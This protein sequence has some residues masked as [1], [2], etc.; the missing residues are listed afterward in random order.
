MN[1]FQNT[2]DARLREWKDLRS[3]VASMSTDDACIAIDHWWQHA[4]LVTHHL[5][6]SD[7]SNWPDPW[8]ML[9]ENTYSTLT[10]AVGICYTLFMCGI[11]DVKLVQAT[12]QQCEDHVLVL[13]GKKPQYILNYW[14]GTVLSNK[15]SDFTVLRELNI[16]HLNDSVR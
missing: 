2:Y 10:R 9:S 7:S 12:D 11:T 14:P 8:T 1:V 4:P 5:H 6:W 13:V 15:I 3:N 16:K